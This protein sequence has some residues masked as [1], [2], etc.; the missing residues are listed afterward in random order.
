[1]QR[2][3]K[4]N[5]R[6]IQ[7]VAQLLKEN[8]VNPS[9]MITLTLLGTSGNGKTEFAKAMAQALF[10]DEKAM[11]KMTFFG[12][13]GEINNYLRSTTG[14]VGSN[15]PTS[16][17]QWMK[18][19]MEKGG[20]IVLDELLSF[21]GLNQQT[22][23][24][25]I[26]TIN[27][28]YELLDERMLQIANKQYDVSKF[29]VIITGNS[30][31][32]LFIGLDDNPDAED[33]V[34]KIVEKLT[35]QDIIH[36]F[37]TKNIDPAKISRFGEIFVNGPLP[38]HETREVG[39]LLLQRNLDQLAKHNTDTKVNVAKEII[40]EIVQK[41]TTVELGMREV[42]MGIR[43]VVMSAINGI[44]FDFPETKNIEAK[45]T[46]DIDKKIHWY[47]DG[48]EIVLAGNIINQ[49]SGLEKQKWRLLSTIENPEVIRTP[50]FKDLNLPAK[51][52]LT[53]LNL[54]IVAIHEIKGHWM[55][56]TLLEGKNMAESVSIIPSGNALGYVR[57]DIDTEEIKHKTLSS[58]L[59]ENMSLE[60]GHRAPIIEGLHASG[61]GAIHQ[62]K[63]K[64]PDDDLGK[65]ARNI[66]AIMN[67]HMVRHF[68]NNSA[69][70]VR[71]DFQEVLRDLG[72][73]ATDELIKFGNA[74]YFSDEIIEQMISEHYLK[75]SDLEYH[76]QKGLASINK[77]RD[78]LFIDSLAKAVQT[79]L[80]KYRA[81]PAKPKSAQTT[82][83]KALVDATLEDTLAIR[84]LDNSTTPEIQQALNR[85]ANRIRG[86]FKK[87]SLQ[88][89]FASHIHRFH[90]SIKRKLPEILA[91]T[92]SGEVL[93]ILE[94]NESLSSRQIT[95]LARLAANDLGK[96]AKNSLP[97]AARK[98]F[99][100]ADVKKSLTE[101]IS[102]SLVPSVI[103]SARH[104]RLKFKR[105]PRRLYGG[106]PAVA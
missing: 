46:G 12:A 23:S 11:H 81:S 47:A 71:L 20:I 96:E 93:D 65:V 38:R 25:K 104:Q 7:R 85:R 28:L 101:N 13:E 80:K 87:E 19:R 89:V 29:H 94:T 21:H 16:F 3:L 68:N 22:I 95:A 37:Q 76:A 106:W 61:G 24:Q 49:N 86:I 103:D 4:G 6:Q 5:T 97:L 31:Q 39:E 14:Y 15:Q 36:Y 99:T 2:N 26:Q 72:K 50:G 67:N 84:A 52:Y 66:K 83:L 27:A 33:I 92:P 32:E 35:K 34:R 60:A 54:L 53:E 98:L 91:T 78:L 88:E 82:M 62:S 64:I 63:D 70:A 55:V 58:L 43:Q 45:I 56:G 57:P 30:L 9:Q 51:K 42:N 40:A 44:I 75:K 8:A 18:A 41:L 69:Q 10:D 105:S 59:K 1:M 102:K 74:K 17:E 77:D 73:Q 79:L 48:K 100:L 90:V